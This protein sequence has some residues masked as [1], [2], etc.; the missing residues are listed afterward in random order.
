M[1]M[2]GDKEH[3]EHI[4]E[5][6]D[7]TGVSWFQACPATSLALIETC[8]L[9]LHAAVLDVGGGDSHLAEALLDRGFNNLWVLDISGKALQKAK[10]RLGERAKC[11]HWIESDVLDFKPPVKFDLWH[12]RAAFHFL[13]TEDNISRYAAMA[14]ERV[15]EGGHL[16]MATFSEVGPEKCSGLEVRRYSEQLLSQVF[17]P[18]FE[19][20]ACMTEDHVTPFNS[21]QNFLFCKFRK[22]APGK[23]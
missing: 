19:K 4:Y 12:D 14:N 6:K 7:E 1:V 21:V 22:A 11:V 2:A 13:T 20:T 5:S 10:M 17:S 16:I 18:Y 8:H 23:S 15:V 9:P 3:W